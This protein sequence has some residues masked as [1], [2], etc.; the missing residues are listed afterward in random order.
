MTTTVQNE[1]LESPKHPSQNESHGSDGAT[2]TTSGS[3][4]VDPVPTSNN[5]AT[6]ACRWARMLASRVGDST[7][8]SGDPA[9]R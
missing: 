4:K 3:F 1:R 9:V 5:G 2:V 7:I 8:S 6:S